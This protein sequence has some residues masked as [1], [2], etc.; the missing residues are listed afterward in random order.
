MDVKR[1]YFVYDQT[2][3]NLEISFVLL[4]PLPL[5]CLQNGLDRKSR[6]TR[7]RSVLVSSYTRR[8]NIEKQEGFGKIQELKRLFGAFWT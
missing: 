2:R 6:E 8:P 3:E 7:M 5:S 4:K 1:Y